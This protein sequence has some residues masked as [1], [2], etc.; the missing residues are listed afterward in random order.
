MVR[1]NKAS[2]ARLLCKAVGIH[3]RRG[4]PNASYLNANEMMQVLQWVNT[5]KEKL[6][7]KG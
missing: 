2:T 3:K 4:K 5:A 6:N 7:A 1:V